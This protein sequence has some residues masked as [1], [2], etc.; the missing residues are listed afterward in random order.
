M[1]NI[2]I[3]SIVISAPQGRSGK[4]TV[5]I[6]LCSAF[7]KRSVIVQPFKKGPDYIDPSWLS[8]AVGRTCRNLDLIL[9][10]E[11]DLI[12][13]FRRTCVGTDLAIIEG[14]MGLYDG[15]ES[16]EKE[17]TAQVARLLNSPVILV[18]NCTRMTQSVAAMVS[19][20]QHFEPGITIAGVILNNVSGNRHEQK[21]RKAIEEHCGIPVL[22]SLPKASQLNITQRHLGLIPYGE[23]DDNKKVLDVYEQMATCFDLD[24]IWQI[25][26]QAKTPTIDVRNVKTDEKKATGL[27]VGVILDQIFNFYYPD[28]L[29]ALVK[30]GA[31]LVYINSLKDK[32][33]PD[34]DGLYIGGGFPEMFLPELQANEGLKRSIAKSIE[35]NLPVYAEC[36]GLMYLCQRIWQNNVGYDMVGILPAEIKIFSRPQ[37]HGYVLVE[38][39]ESPLFPK[40]ISFWGHEFHYSKLSLTSELEFGY[41]M[42]RGQG[43]NG[44]ADGIIYKNLFA[45]YLHLFAPGMQQWAPAFVRLM[46]KVKNSRLIS[47]Q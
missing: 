21:L 29:E 24:A 47:I 10:S 8:A 42:K 27:R 31:E 22:G 3:P 43:I 11:E 2:T 20:Y 45:S 12:G 5:A 39:E 28:N 37:G 7:K 40:G 18:V 25:A 33:L 6:A 41:H 13:S 9:M 4:T 14:A 15:F 17:S 23:S 32:E 46:Q 19:G 44:K 36:A 34:I 16:G 38:T 30:E 26:S 1:G 35:N